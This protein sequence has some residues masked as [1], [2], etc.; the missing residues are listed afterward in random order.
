MKRSFYKP[1]LTLLTAMALLPGTATAQQGNKYDKEVKAKRSIRQLKEGVL[2]VR[3]QTSRNQIRA[4]EK[5]GNTEWAAE[6]RT[7]QDSINQRIVRSFRE[8]FDFCRV[9]FFYSHH[10]D[11]IRAKRFERVLMDDSL[12]PV[13]PSLKGRPIFTLS[14]G[15]IYFEAYRSSFKGLAVMDDQLQQLAPP[16]PYYVKKREGLFFLRRTYPKMIQ[17]LE[18]QLQEFYENQS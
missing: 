11:S 1:L 6:I 14:T 15:T 3:L 9:Y 12:Q 13:T 10:S 17:V 7:D 5:S 4:L 18:E 2:L 8:D 16:F